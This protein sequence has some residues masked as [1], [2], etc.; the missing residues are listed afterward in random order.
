[1]AA[2]RWISGYW[3]DGAHPNDAGYAEFYYAFVPS[4]FDAV[5][6]G[7]TNRPA[8]RLRHQ[9]RPPDLQRRGQRAADLHPLQ[10]RAFLHHR[11]PPA[12]QRHRH[13]SPRYARGA[14]YA[15]LEVRTGQ[16]VYV[17]AFRNGDRPGHQPGQRDLARCRALRPLCASPTPPSTSTA[18]WPVL[19]PNASR[20]TSSSSA[21]PGPP[22]APPP[23]PRW[24]STPG[25]CT[26]RA[27]RRTRP[28]PRRTAAC[29]SRAWRSA[30]C[31]MTHRSST[32]PPPRN[33]AQSLSQA[34]RSTRP[35]SPRGAMRN[36]PS[37]KLLIF[38]SSVAKGWNGG[39]PETNGSVTNSAL[40]AA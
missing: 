40:P 31:W 20:P 4:L 24:I 13:R 29:S 39:G 38:G 27:G 26:A 2:G 22:A 3:A 33:V 14:D 19:S 7:R 16:L 30:P 36:P 1:M 32:V 35:T 37:P 9:L 5:A 10:H 8:I 25:A 11:L 23:R 12:H 21:D 18:R 34:R 17:S 15:T 28:S 6:A